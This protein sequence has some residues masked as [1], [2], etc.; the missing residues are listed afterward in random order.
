MLI[1]LFNVQI[2]REQ[3]GKTN[4]KLIKINFNSKWLHIKVHTQVLN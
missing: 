4:H 1:H 2:E 3:A